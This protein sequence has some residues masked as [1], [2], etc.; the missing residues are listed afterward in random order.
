MA[1]FKIKERPIEEIETKLAIRDLEVT[2]VN[3]TMENLQEVLLQKKQEFVEKLNEVYELVH[4]KGKEKGNQ[5]NSLIISELLFEPISKYYSTRPEYTA[6][7]LTIAFELYR[8]MVKES[9]MKGLKVIPSKSHFSRF[10]G[11]S[12]TTYDAYKD[13]TDLSMRNLMEV[14]DDYIY[15]ANT[16][17]A[18]QREIDTITTMFKA[19]VDHKKVEATTPQVHIFS[20]DADM[21]KIL[22][23]IQRLKQ[24][25]KVRVIDHDEVDRHNNQHNGTKKLATTRPSKS[26]K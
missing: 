6:E 17:S 5:L 9:N 4:S 3:K 12:T 8:E 26:N 2:L 10:C 23:D 16:S 1:N 25:N 15:D 13:S 14:V 21:E 22:E 19:K 7:K 20:P 11:F 24:G 18:Q